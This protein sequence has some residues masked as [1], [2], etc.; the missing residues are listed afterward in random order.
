MKLAFSKQA[1][2]VFWTAD[3]CLSACLSVCLSVCIVACVCV[4]G[5]NF[6]KDQQAMK[7][8]LMQLQILLTFVDPELANYLG[9]LLNHSSAQLMI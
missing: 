2:S 9:Q 6:D 5:A 4:Q 8:Q 3:F 1:N 7:N